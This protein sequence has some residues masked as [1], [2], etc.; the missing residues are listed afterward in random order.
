MALQGYLCEARIIETWGG[1]EADSAALATCRFPFVYDGKTYDH[2]AP[3][4]TD[5]DNINSGDYPWCSLSTD[6]ADNTVHPSVAG[7]WGKCLD[8]TLIT[9]NYLSGAHVNGQHCQLPFIMNGK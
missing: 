8:D 6:P 4:N 5:K 7:S 2:C 9:Y 3:A 1:V